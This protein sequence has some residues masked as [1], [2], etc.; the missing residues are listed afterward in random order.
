MYIL[1]DRGKNKILR[2]NPLNSC[3]VRLRNFLAFSVM[4]SSAPNA[5]TDARKREVRNNLVKTD[6]GRDSPSFSYKQ[7]TTIFT[8]HIVR[9]VVLHPQILLWILGTNLA[10]MEIIK[11]IL[12]IFNLQILQKNH[13]LWIFVHC[14][15]GT[16]HQRVWVLRLPERRRQAAV[17]FRARHAMT[18]CR[19]NFYGLIFR[20]W[21]FWS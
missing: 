8:T 17:P 4:I 12:V 16:S 7:T 1:Y 9:V 2:L 3:Y 10:K 20:N 19:R 13:I 21:F 14:S 11:P 18:F 15:C 5:K 6:K